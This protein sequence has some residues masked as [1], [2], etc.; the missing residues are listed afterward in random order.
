[1]EHIWHDYT[2]YYKCGEKV[3]ATS[4][5][6]ITEWNA[7]LFQHPVVSK[8][9]EEEERQGCI[10]NLGRKKLDKPKLLLCSV[11]E[12]C[13]LTASLFLSAYQKHVTIYFKPVQKAGTKSRMNLRCK[14]FDLS[15]YGVIFPCNTGF[16]PFP[17]L[18]FCKFMPCFLRR[19][20]CA[21]PRQL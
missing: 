15:H 1:M 13:F 16:S 14:F 2:S 8:Q 3:V 6:R 12:C 20:A 7:A 19:F 5:K 11:A 21:L 9:Q 10:L 4:C 17:K 18:P